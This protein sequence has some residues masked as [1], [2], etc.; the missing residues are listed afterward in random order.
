METEKS[1]EKVLA[2]SNLPE[3]IV[4]AKPAENALQS[5]EGKQQLSAGS[6]T[7]YFTWRGFGTVKLNCSNAAIRTS[8]RV[9][10]SVTEYNTDPNQNPIMG[11][12]VVTTYNVVPYNGG[13]IVR[14]YVGFS[15]ALNIKV[16]VLIDP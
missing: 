12:A 10:A 9:F 16:S 2:G 3:E 15:T 4:H 5:G 13:V 11:D 6:F 14:L 8:S 7:T 1:I